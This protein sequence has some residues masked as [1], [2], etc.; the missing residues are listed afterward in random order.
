[1][2]TVNVNKSDLASILAENRK[3]HKAEYEE[4][5]EG[6]IKTAIEKLEENLAKFKEGEITKLRWNEQPPTSNVKDYDRVIKMLEMSTDDKIELT[7]EEFENFVQDDWHWKETWRLS[8]SKYMT[9][10]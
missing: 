1:M 2:R 3:K 5:F 4:A 8:N 6:Y 7:S 9:A 10:S